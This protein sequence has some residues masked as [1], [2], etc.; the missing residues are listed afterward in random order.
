MRRWC[1]RSY[2]SIGHRIFPNQD[3]ARRL[4]YR[5]RAF[6]FGQIPRMCL[7]NIYAKENK[8]GGIF[9]AY[10]PFMNA[11]HITPFLFSSLDASG[12]EPRLEESA[13]SVPTAEEIQ[14]QVFAAAQRD[15]WTVGYGEGFTAGKDEGWI[16]G[17]QEGRIA[18]NTEGLAA[19]ATEVV[20]LR[21]LAAELANWEEETREFVERM[22][23]SIALDVARFVI[24]K[25]T[26]ET[27]AGALQ[28]QLQNLLKTLPLPTLTPHLVLHP[29][30]IESLQDSA[31]GAWT[32]T[33][34]P[35]MERGGVRVQARPPETSGQTTGAEKFTMPEWDARIE[36]RWGEA[37]SKLTGAD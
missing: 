25:E 1:Q 37:L 31:P 10:I 6:P 28:Q 35:L 24:R 16:A 21:T 12:Q 30:D 32:I 23:L 20:F 33:P 26:R 29:D 3:Q 8:Y 19:A 27:T 5:S 11:T 13:L 17:K 18:G 15:G 7:N 4:H 36:T 22:T 14:A 9:I 34:D 2:L